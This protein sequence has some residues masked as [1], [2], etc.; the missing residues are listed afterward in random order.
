[1]FSQSNTIPPENVER[2][3]KTLLVVGDEQ[4][5]QS[6][7]KLE[8]PRHEGTTIVHCFLNINKPSVSQSNISVCEP[9]SQIN[10]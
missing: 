3:K 10:L 2:L 4:A 9:Y 8:I 1:M 7:W 5:K 6:R